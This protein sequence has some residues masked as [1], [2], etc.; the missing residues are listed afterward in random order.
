MLFQTGCL[1]PGAERLPEEF[2]STVAR[3][4]SRA[5]EPSVAPQYL[6]KSRQ[7]CIYDGS[8]IK[9][10]DWTENQLSYPHNVAQQPGLGLPYDR[11]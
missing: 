7:V 8:T 5:L 3:W 10:H 4:T 6:R 2:F 11:I 9:M 1:L